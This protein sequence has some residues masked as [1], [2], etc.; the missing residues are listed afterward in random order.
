MENVWDK[1]NP[2]KIKFKLLPATA[3]HWKGRGDSELGSLESPLLTPP[4]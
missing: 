3:W 4:I 1:S 2:A